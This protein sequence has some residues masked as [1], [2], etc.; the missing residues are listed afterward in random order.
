MELVLNNTDI[1]ALFMNDGVD[2]I[3]VTTDIEALNLTEEESSIKTIE[4][5]SWIEIADFGMKN[6]I[7]SEYFMTTKVGYDEVCAVI[8]RYTDTD[9]ETFI[10]KNFTEV[11]L[12]NQ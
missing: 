5:F 1:K 12:N 2:E 7:A 6:I 10:N 4:D 9:A 8:I 3:L 11:I